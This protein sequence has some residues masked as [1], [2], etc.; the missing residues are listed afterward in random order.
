MNCGCGKVISK[1]RIEQLPETRVCAECSRVKPYRGFITATPRH[2][3]I[4]VSIV[5]DEEA[6]K[7]MERYAKVRTRG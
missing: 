3:G 6:A 1:E 7:A 4:H 2:K 5:R